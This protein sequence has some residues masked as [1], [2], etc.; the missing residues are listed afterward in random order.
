[1]GREERKTREERKAGEGCL[2][3]KGRV[4]KGLFRV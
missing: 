4:F 2:L 1:M 3:N